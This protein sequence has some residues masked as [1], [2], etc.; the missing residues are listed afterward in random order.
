MYRGR[1]KTALES[2]RQIANALLAL[3]EH[4]SY[5]SISVSAVC[6]QADISRQTFYSLFQ[7]M[8]NVVTY[9]LQQDCCYD[10]APQKTACSGTFMDMCDGFSRYIIDHADILQL[11]SNNRIMPL[12]RQVLLEDFRQCITVSGC[13]RQDL[14]PYAIDYLASGITSIAEMYVRQGRRESRERLCEIIYTLLTGQCFHV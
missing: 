14:A 10:A 2:Q 8:D 12:L 5:A 3:L 6:H 13:V 11:L 9:A 7:S 4:E 1:N